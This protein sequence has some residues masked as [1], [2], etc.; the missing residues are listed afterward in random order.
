MATIPLSCS[1][2]SA[3]N[4][5]AN[6]SDGVA[7]T[8]LQLFVLKLVYADALKL[9]YFVALKLVYFVVLKLVNAVFLK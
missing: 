8:S 3:F 1:S 2:L 7:I 5:V 9:V 4:E 6:F